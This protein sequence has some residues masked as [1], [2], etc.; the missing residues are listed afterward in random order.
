ML[1]FCL[2]IQI[3]K[4]DLDIKKKDESNG[5]LKI[6]FKGDTGYNVPKLKINLTENYP[7][8]KRRI[9]LIYLE[10][11]DTIYSLE[12]RIEKKEILI[13]IKQGEYFASITNEELF[14]S[15]A[16]FIMPLLF[17]EDKYIG[18]SLGFDERYNPNAYRMNSIKSGKCS[19]SEKERSEIFWPVFLTEIQFNHCPKLKIVGNK[20]TEVVIT[21]SNEK[22][23]GWRSFFGVIPGALI[24]IPLFGTLVYKSDST[25]EIKYPDDSFIHNNDD[26]KN[27]K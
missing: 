2:P 4:S 11:L 25:A 24:G 16:F 19:T 1:M 14:G 3:R 26:V 18:I 21:F 12:G 10:D 22:L 5:Y 8:I 13:P 17:Q 6:V 27:K 23:D 7:K 9:P 20:V 15:A